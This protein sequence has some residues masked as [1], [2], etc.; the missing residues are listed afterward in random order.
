MIH[1]LDCKIINAAFIML[2]SFYVAHCQNAWSGL[3]DKQVPAWPI[4]R[5]DDDDD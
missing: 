5:P 2:P 3:A 1:F 4:R